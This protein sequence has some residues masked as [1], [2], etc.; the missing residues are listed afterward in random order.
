MAGKN[1]AAENR[2]T[3]FKRLEKEPWSFG[4][5]MALRR[6]E[7]LRLTK[8]RLGKSAK[9]KDDPIRLGQEPSL[10]FA[11][12]TLQSFKQNK[13]S[14][15]L[16]KVFFFGVFGPNGPLPLH[17]T[18]Y[19]R[20]R[21]RN[22]ND[23]S[24]TRFMDIFHHRFLSLFY[25]SWADAQPTVNLD[26]PEDDAFVNRVGSLLGVGIPE[27]QSRDALPDFAK[28]HFAGQLG[29]Q[30]RNVEGLLALLKSYF[31]M[32]VKMQQ[33]VGSWLKIPEE[34]YLRLGGF[35]PAA[36]GM[37]TT[38]GA[39]VWEV[40]HKFRLTVGPLSISEYQRLLPGGESLM[41]MIACVRN[42]LGDQLAWDVNLILSRD[43]IKPAALGSFG[44][45]GWT[46]WLAGD[47][48]DED[49]AD[50]YLDPMQ[51]LI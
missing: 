43:E 27:M 50:F 26:R 25:R 8:A 23:H 39:R 9:P 20:D 32:P 37:T 30:C 1:R 19:A 51:Q 18:E 28:L 11:P 33:F 3:E 22:L 10:A 31:E 5:F 21:Q 24:F 34:S 29:S 12:S 42:Y 14:A 38:L 44:Q 49:L 40:Q 13:G 41:R 48:P 17:L 6:V 47:K 45:L 35:S 7:A 2:L 46:T 15:P 36:L 4:F 16:L